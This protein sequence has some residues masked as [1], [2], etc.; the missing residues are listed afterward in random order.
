MNSSVV[1]KLVS[2]QKTTLWKMSAMDQP[3]GKL[4]LP[5]L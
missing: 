1:K 5:S 4:S 3:T 2:G